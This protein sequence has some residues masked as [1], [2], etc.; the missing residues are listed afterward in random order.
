MKEEAGNADLLFIFLC[1][2]FCASAECLTSVRNEVKRKI[3]S[4]FS[5]SIFFWMRSSPASRR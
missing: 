3:A 2:R 4:Y 5:S 1:L